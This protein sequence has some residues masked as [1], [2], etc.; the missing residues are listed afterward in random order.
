MSS[1]EAYLATAGRMFQ[2]T[3][4]QDEATNFFWVCMPA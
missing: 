2:V 3:N 1:P 4:D